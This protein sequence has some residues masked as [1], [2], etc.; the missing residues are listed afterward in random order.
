M[1]NCTDIVT[2]AD[3]PLSTYRSHSSEFYSYFPGYKEAVF[4]SLSG[5]VIIY[6]QYK[7]AALRIS[8]IY[9]DFN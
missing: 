6:V 7:L 9:G 5:F 3:S 4:F 1:D 2:I 8:G